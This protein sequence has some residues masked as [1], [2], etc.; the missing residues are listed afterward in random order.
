MV[1][2]KYKREFVGEAF[3]ACKNYGSS[4]FSY[5]SHLVQGGTKVATFSQ[6]TIV[7]NHGSLGSLAT[8]GK[9][10]SGTG[11]QKLEDKN[12]AIFSKAIVKN[13]PSYKKLDQ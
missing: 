6:K 11:G 10:L 2:A 8:I 13:L 3:G 7:P 1:T 5:E 4:R 12:V 9:Q